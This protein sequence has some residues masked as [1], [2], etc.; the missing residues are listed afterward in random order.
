MTHCSFILGPLFGVAVFTT[1]TSIG[2][3]NT[4]K[5]LVIS[6]SKWLNRDF[7]TSIS[8]VVH[9]ST[10]IWVPIASKTLNTAKQ[11]VGMLVSF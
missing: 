2:V 5:T 4:P 9:L 1:D 3:V 6:F 8:S 7:Y 11:V 10:R